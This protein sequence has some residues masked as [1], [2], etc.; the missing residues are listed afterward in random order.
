LAW[1]IVDLNW[2]SWGLG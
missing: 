1:N 2:C